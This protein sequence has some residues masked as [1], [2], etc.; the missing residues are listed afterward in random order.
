MTV[1][2]LLRQSMA[3]HNQYKQLARQRDKVGARAEMVKARDLRRQAITLDPDRTDPQ[4]AVEQTN[5]ATHAN[6]HDELTRFYVEQL[7]GA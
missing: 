5:T 3:A 4:W 1:A 6:T 7:G 2:D